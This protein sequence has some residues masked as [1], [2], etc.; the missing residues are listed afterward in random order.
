MFESKIF[1]Y[2]KELIISILFGFSALAIYYVSSLFMTVYYESFVF[3]TLV[4]ITSELIKDYFYNKIKCFYFNKSFFSFIKRSSLSFIFSIPLLFGVNI[5][6]L[7]IDRFLKACFF[8]FF[9]FT[10]ILI[11]F[12]NHIGYMKKVKIFF[13]DSFD[14]HD[15][16]FDFTMDF[17]KV[18][19]FFEKHSIT[20]RKDYDLI[21]GYLTYSDPANPSIL[22]ELHFHSSITNSNISS[23]VVLDNIQ[24]TVETLSSYLKSSNITFEQLMKSKDEIDLFKMYLN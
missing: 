22:F 3:V 17:E 8:S 7:D 16:G 20:N 4:V 24:I 23:I 13:K 5:I 1:L 9:I 15:N 11:F 19:F 21:D 6:E 18:E 10:L 12:V 2:H 14:N